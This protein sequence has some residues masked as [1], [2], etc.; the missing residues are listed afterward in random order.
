[1]GNRESISPFYWDVLKRA[2]KIKNDLEANHSP[3]TKE[4][5]YL[6]GIAF[7]GLIEHNT[8]FRL[9]QPLK[10]ITKTKKLGF[11]SITSVE[12][13][14]DER[15]EQVFLQDP[16]GVEYSCDTQLLQDIMKQRYRT[17]VLKEQET[18]QKEEG[19]AAILVPDLEEETKQK[20]VIKMAES[21]EKQ[22]AE[23]VHTKDRLPVFSKEEQFRNDR[24]GQKQ[25]ETFWCS[26]HD[27][28]ITHEGAHGTIHFYV[29][30]L[31]IK[32]NERATDVFV[33]AES[34]GIC[35]TALSRGEVSS[36]ELEFEGVPF[37][38][39]GSF[40]NGK[41]ISMVKPLLA[42]VAENYQ[43]KVIDRSSSIRTSTTYVQTEYR[44]L[45]FNIFP[46]MFGGNGSRGFAPA[47]IVIERAGQIEIS[48]PT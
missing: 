23:E 3:E 29:Y 5:R 40:Q 34:G 24:D 35:R 48:T 41:F 4:L 20:T 18:I 11:L 37:A 33:I 46:A 39:R 42:D 8:P 12:S 45:K 13:T 15:E 32:E 9:V 21:E 27:L 1:M 28:T 31:A 44:G 7:A 30:P 6:R 36:V 47:G 43:E 26:Q 22:L 38:I 17:L 25:I 16:E 19:E 14:E 10:E 2:E